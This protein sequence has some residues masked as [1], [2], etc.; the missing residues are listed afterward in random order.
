MD[1]IAMT[2]ITPYLVI[3]GLVAIALALV[4]LLKWLGKIL[5]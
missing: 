4:F 3:S 5:D 2:V 1:A